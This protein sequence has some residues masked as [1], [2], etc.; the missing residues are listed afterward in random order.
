MAPL[1][2]LIWAQAG[3]IIRP[4]NNTTTVAFKPGIELPSFAI[5]AKSEL[6]YL[7]AQLTLKVRRALG[8]VSRLQLQTTAICYKE[9]ISDSTPV[10]EKAARQ[11]LSQKTNRFSDYVTLYRSIAV[12]PRMPLILIQIFPV[13]NNFLGLDKPLP[14]V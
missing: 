14:S 8:R 3:V 6:H 10:E 9:L 12:S 1:E 7:G 11:H 5:L 2:E 4:N 13:V